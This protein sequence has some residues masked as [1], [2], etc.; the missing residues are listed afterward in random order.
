VSVDD[1]APMS[2]QCI[3]ILDA[4]MIIHPRRRR[5]S[6]LDHRAAGITRVWIASSWPWRSGAAG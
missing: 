4:L 5:R 1:D 6:V 3:P 2:V